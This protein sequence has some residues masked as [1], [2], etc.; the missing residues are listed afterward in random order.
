MEMFITICFRLFAWSY[1]E[2]AWLMCGVKSLI[3][4]MFLGEK[5]GLRSIF[6]SRLV[7]CCNE[8][9]LGENCLCNKTL[10]Q[11]VLNIWWLST[12]KNVW[13]FLHV[14]FITSR[15][16]LKMLHVVFCEEWKIF[17]NFLSRLLRQIHLNALKEIRRDPY[18]TK[19]FNERR[20]VLNWDK[21]GGFHI[22]N[23][24]SLKLYSSF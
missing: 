14:P 23:L 22:W 9:R 1:S 11:I 13:G 17:E 7:S 15:V 12:E 16:C 24:Y 10:K 4:K 21:K 20:G 8:Y 3:C 2:F 5:K 6:S 19:R 18:I